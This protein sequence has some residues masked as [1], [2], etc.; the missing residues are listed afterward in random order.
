MRR[1]W[2][3]LLL[4]LIAGGFYFWLQSPQWLEEWNNAHQQMISAE[5]QAG[6]Q[7]GRTTDQQGC[8]D[9]AL[10]KTEQ[11][12]ESEYRCTVSGGTYLKACWETSLPSATFCDGVPAY[13]EEPTEDDKAWV[14]G[15][16]DELGALSKSCRL[17][18]RQQQQICAAQ[19]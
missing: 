13:H 1:F 16:C 10:E 2:L 12:K 19:P 17:L 8:F 14:K 3:T 18:V 4:V 7:F 11:C 9:Q 6:Q 15:R 5:R